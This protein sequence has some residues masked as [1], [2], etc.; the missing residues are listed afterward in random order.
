MKVFGKTV[1]IKPDILPIRTE[2][3]ALLVPQNS[4]ELLPEWGVAV[5]TGPSCKQVR[6]GD[7]VHFPRKVASVIVIDNEDFYFVPEH[8]IFY[9]E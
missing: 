3:G 5:Q 1:L 9:H 6:V 7:R 2:S 4:K 8:R